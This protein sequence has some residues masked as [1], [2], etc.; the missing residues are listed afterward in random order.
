MFIKLKT[1]YKLLFTNN[2]TTS[3]ID[4][5]KEAALSIVSRLKFYVYLLIHSDNLRSEF[6]HHLH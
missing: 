5:Q 3:K 1:E 2:L 4:S 6:S